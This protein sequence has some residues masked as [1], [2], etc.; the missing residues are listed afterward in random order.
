MLPGD[1]PWDAQTLAGAFGSAGPLFIDVGVGDGRA[2][3]AWADEH[4]Q[5]CVLAIELHRPG[6]AR[7]LT[8]LEAHGPPNVRVVEADALAVL[9]A[10]DRGSVAA[11]RLLFPD[12]WPKRRHMKRRLVDRGFVQRAADLLAP[13]GTL[14]VATDWA[15]YAE[16]VRTA[17]ATEPRFAP[18]ADAGRPPRP[19]TTYESRGLRAGR[20]ILDLVHRRLPDR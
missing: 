13:G 16:H 6:I 10:L 15:D 19:T 5:A 20:T 3:R 9:D 1:G 2:T 14:H 12:P 7:L 11:I 18:V 17:V 8:D 4:P